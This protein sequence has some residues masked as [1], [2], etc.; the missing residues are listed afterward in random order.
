MSDPLPEPVAWTP[1]VLN[2]LYKKNLKALA[3]IHGVQ[4]FSDTG[5]APTNQDY[6]NLLLDAKPRLT[7]SSSNTEGVGNK[8]M[9][10][11]VHYIFKRNK[12]VPWMALTS[13]LITT[14][15]TIWSVAVDKVRFTPDRI[16][17]FPVCEWRFPAESQA[18]INAP[19]LQYPNFDDHPETTFPI[20][21]DLNEGRVIPEGLSES[22]YKLYF[23]V[24]DVSGSASEPKVSANQPWMQ[25]GVSQFRRRLLDP[26]RDA[27]KK[28]GKDLTPKEKNILK[29][30]D[31]L[32]QAHEEINFDRAAFVLTAGKLL[33]MEK[34]AFRGA[35]QAH[36]RVALLGKNLVPIPLDL[37]VDPKKNES[38]LARGRSSPLIASNF[39]PLANSPVENIATTLLNLASISPESSGDD[40][41]DLRDKAE[42][43]DTNFDELWKEVL[44]I[45]ENVHANNFP[46]IN[47]SPPVPEIHLVIFS[48]FIHDVANS[49]SLRLRRKDVERDL[50]ND[51]LSTRG[52]FKTICS[53]G[54][55]SLTAVAP[56]SIAIGSPSEHYSSLNVLADASVLLPKDFYRSHRIEEFALATSSAATPVRADQQAVFYH[57]GAG[58]VETHLEIPFPT[59]GQ[60]EMRW[61]VDS[62]PLAAGSY[63]VSQSGLLT[64][65]KPVSVG[66]LYADQHNKP[67]V[68]DVG[69][70][71]PTLTLRLESPPFKGQETVL[72]SSANLP[73]PLLLT[74]SCAEVISHSISWVL[75]LIYIAIWVGTAV[76]MA[77]ILGQN[78]DS[79]SRLLGAFFWIGS[80]VSAGFL[81]CALPFSVHASWI[82]GVGMVSFF[83]ILLVILLWLMHDKSFQHESTHS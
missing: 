15:I 67:L 12:I 28:A 7:G 81:G 71:A 18:R 51:W 46:H 58:D 13:L 53:T 2:T 40:F 56:E 76:I 47:G 64:N 57:N 26:I 63:S 34:F 55:I 49:T 38:K 59:G 44:R 32:E 9:K 48:D 54:F 27:Q 39:T 4:I 72:I 23:F 45:A 74:L 79:K 61:F 3:D 16:F 83:M 70:V 66:H 82:I 60:I 78:S 21:A 24:I 25:E 80:F 33:Q 14:Y 31:F 37:G 29:A 50:M 22:T 65:N 73:S 41:T 6:V 19:F 17:P 69:P 5:G 8:E 68:F 43:D 20:K 75:F 52:S 1:N 35:A 30:H 36:F 10:K 77:L 42:S 62:A 11:E